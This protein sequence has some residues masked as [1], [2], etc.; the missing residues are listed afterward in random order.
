[1]NF[2]YRMLLRM[3]KWLQKILG[4]TTVG[5][6]AIV[7]RGD[8]VLLIKHTYMPGWYIPGGG[9]DRGEDPE[10]AVIR[11]LWEEVGV[12]PQGRPDLFGVYYH[13]YKEVDDYPIVYIVRD[14]DQ[15]PIRSG[16]ISA[17]QWCP[18][19]CLPDDISPGTQ[20]RLMEFKGDIPKSNTW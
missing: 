20:R 9:V 18:L 14:F 16:E 8:E 10:R 13:V 19:C 17:S 5:V 11:E 4:N 15:V 7:V 2:F 3:Q 1:M 12:I 6:R